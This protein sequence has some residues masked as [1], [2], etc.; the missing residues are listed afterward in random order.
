MNIHSAFLWFVELLINYCEQNI[1]S[2]P[3]I[4]FRLYNRPITDDANIA[5][6]ES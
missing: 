5:I 2:F 4:E 1:T 6:G 3:I